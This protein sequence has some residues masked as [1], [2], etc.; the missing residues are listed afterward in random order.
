MHL[1]KYLMLQSSLLSGETSDFPEVD[2]EWPLVCHLST[3][4]SHSRIYT[5][6][7]FSALRVDLGY[8]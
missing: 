6:D 8:P 1:L 2:Q 3:V 4:V 7:T 5:V